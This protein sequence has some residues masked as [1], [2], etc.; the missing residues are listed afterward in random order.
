MQPAV[1][2]LCAVLAA[3]AGCCVSCTPLWGCEQAALPSGS[4]HV[5]VATFEADP[6]QLLPWMWH[7]GLTGADIFVYYRHD[8]KS[9]SQVFQDV[10]LPCDMR[11]HVLQVR[12]LTPGTSKW[13]VANDNGCVGCTQA[14]Y[15]ASAHACAMAVVVQSVPPACFVL[16][17]VVVPRPGITPSPTRPTAASVPPHPPPHPH[18]RRVSGALQMS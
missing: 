17:C 1:L 15:E 18:P 13:A 9:H 7:L 14:S 12:P 5:V 3:S 8:D 10:Q 11:L 6:H 2:V 16:P 4:L